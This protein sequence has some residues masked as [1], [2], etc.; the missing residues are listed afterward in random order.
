MRWYEYLI[1]NFPEHYS[2]YQLV[3]ETVINIC[4]VK[5]KQMFINEQ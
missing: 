3:L 2:V 1:V 4:I 5:I